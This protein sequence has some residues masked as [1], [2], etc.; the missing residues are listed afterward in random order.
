MSATEAGQNTTG[1]KQS[2]RVLEG[3]NRPMSRWHTAQQYER[4]Y[5]ETLAAAIM[6]GRVKQLDWYQYRARQLA[7]RLRASGLGGLA[8]GQARV[9]EVGAGPIGIINYFPAQER[10][11]VDPLEEFYSSNAALTALRDDDV[12]F[13]K[14]TGEELPCETA[15][16]D[17]VILDN[18]IDHVR[19][20]GGVMA[21]VMRVL[22]SGGVLHLRVNARTAWGF[23]VHRVLSA[24]RI[25]AGHPHTFTP[26]RVER[27]LR[28][29][30]LEV[31]S[32]EVGSFSDAWWRDVRGPE[33]KS[34][35]KAL[36]GVSHFLVAALARK[37]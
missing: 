11:A 26:T 31:L 4:R 17:L 14:G 12:R 13:V 1:K 16:Y 27:T 21:E 19:D 28:T 5:W 10:V 18:C 36:L 32:F 23:W 20:V 3:S 2:G 37:P 6:E 29:S 15:R 35:F 34:R 9:V 33:L 25:D 7:E 30:G 24:L 22:R 8:E